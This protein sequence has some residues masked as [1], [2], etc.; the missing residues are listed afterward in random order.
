[1]VKCLTTPLKEMGYDI[2]IF[3]SC[4][5]FIEQPY[6]VIKKDDGT[7][8]E[9]LD[10]YKPISYFHEAYTKEIKQQLYI[11]C[12]MNKFQKDIKCK[13]QQ[14]DL[15]CKICGAKIVHNQLGMLYNIKKS[16]MLKIQYEINSGHTYSYVIR[17]RFD[18]ALFS[19]LKNVHLDSAT[20]KTII[21]PKG[22]DNT[23]SDTSGPDDQLIIGTSEIMN[24]YSDTYNHIYEYVSQ[25]YKQ[26]KTWGLPHRALQMQLKTHN[27]KVVRLPFKRA[28]YQKLDKFGYSKLYR[29]M[30]V[31]NDKR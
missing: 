1:M 7:F 2:D 21:I 28:L 3:I 18:L 26:Y 20:S 6:K 9:V 23:G 19:L 5:K 25:N 27:I 11:E 8:Q 13:C 10:L 30:Y 14:K 12:G 24:I 29:K 16:N 22:N 31:S 15:K 17:Y 4:W